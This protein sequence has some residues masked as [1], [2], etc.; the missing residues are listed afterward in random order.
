MAAIALERTWADDVKAL[1]E[2]EA[3]R[4][5]L[6][7]E[8]ERLR[9]ALK[10]LIPY[11]DA[12]GCGGGDCPDY[13]TCDDECPPCV[14]AVDEAKATALEVVE[15]LRAG[16]EDGTFVELDGESVVEIVREPVSNYTQGA[17]L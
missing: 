16:M 3:E 6:A 9:G 4:D 2:A 1:R 7:A 5:A 8:V 14:M 11:N 15:A 12:M 10:K 17:L 13:D